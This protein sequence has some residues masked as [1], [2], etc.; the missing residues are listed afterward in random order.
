MMLTAADHRIV[1]L[2]DVWNTLPERVRAAD[3]AMFEAQGRDEDEYEAEAERA[4]E[5]RC[6][7]FAGDA[8]LTG[9]DWAG[10]RKAHGNEWLVL[11]VNGDLDFAG[12]SLPACYVAGDV[13]CDSLHASPDDAPVVGGRITARHYAAFIGG[14]DETLHCAFNGR[15][16]TPHAFFW[17]HDWRGVELNGDAVVHILCDHGDFEEPDAPRWFYWHDGLLALRPELTYA[18]ATWGSDELLWR[19]DDLGRRVGAGEPVFIDGFDPACLPLVNQAR[20]HLRHQQYPQALAHYK[21]AIA[22]ASGYRIAWAGAARTLYLADALEQALPYAERAMALMPDKLRHLKDEAADDRALCLLRLGRWDE[23]LAGASDIIERCKDESGRAVAHRVRGEAFLRRGA[24]EKARDD[25]LQAA[26]TSYSS[27]LYQWLAGLAHHKLGDH[28]AAE[29]LRAKAGRINEKYAMAFEGHEGSGFRYAPPTT[30]D[31]EQQTLADLP[32]EVRDADYWHRYLLS[33]AYDSAKSFRAIPAEFLTRDFCLEAIERCPHQTDI[34]VAQFFPEAVFDETL[35]ARL[36][37]RSAGN[38]G[39]IPQRLV[40]K[41]LLL[42]AGEGRCDPALVPPQLLDAE[43]CRRLVERQVPPDAL[44]PQ[45]VDHALCLHAVR[46]WSNAIEHVPGAFKDE[47]FY[48][49]ALAWADSLWFIENR[50]PARYHAPDMLCRAL[51]MNF[52]LIHHIPGRLVDEEVF[53]HARALCP[54]EA[55]W[56]QLTTAHGRGFRQASDRGEYLDCAEDCW[57][58]FWDEPLM[59]AEIANTGYHLFPFEIPAAKYTQTIADAAFARDPIHLR[60]IP[61]AFI[62]P[63]MAERFAREYA[64]MLHDVPLP[65][66]TARVCQIAAEHSWDD[67]KYFRHV[68]L[69]L[70]GVDACIAALGK[71]VDNADFI[72]LAARHAVYDRLVQGGGAK[73]FAIGWLLNER[74]LGALAL[75]RVDEAVA[76]FDTV[77]ARGRG[78]RKPGLLGA[79]FGGRPAWKADDFDEDDIADARLYKAWACRQQGRLDAMHEALA[80]LDEAQRAHLDIFAPAEAPEAVEFPLEA[81]EAHIGAAGQYVE[82]G[83]YRSALDSALQARTLLEEAQHPDPRLWAYALDHL[84]FIT[85]ELG[86]FDENERLCRQILERLQPV[87]DWPYLEEHN[88][89]RAARRG[90]HN[91]LAWKLADSQDAAD[92][93]QAVTHARAALRH[94][95]IED[96]SVVHPFLETAARAL[97]RA[98]EADPARQ[99]EARRMLERIAALGLAQ[100]GG[101]TDARVL[102]ALQALA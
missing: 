60:S 72:P 61:R 57:A 79:L 14:D 30:V 67:G 63:Q 15:V 54:D 92:I 80:P 23:A 77:I 29:A 102:A 39:Y 3:R 45:W 62:T 75:G 68:P 33:Q 8:R 55:L 56:A 41:A 98:A 25:L 84:R 66:R 6:V 100:K 76:D 59:L 51:D 10:L 46:H 88:I 2:G 40:T 11:V 31:W 21:A 17:F 78:T 13:V 85:W 90:A 93:A 22:L 9:D 52:G 7:F 53:A 37:E 43:L 101:I 49:T 94:A 24:L 83:D 19:L 89:L 87:A 16:T 18:P 69:A 82:G 42:R 86:R 97:L 4:R 96:E 91:T 27:A 47:A 74:G 38:L 44:P 99:D 20:T 28:G 50:L 65:L 48:L 73:D 95:P 12:R 58:V 71:S 32:A 26:K 70:R 35:A 36:I 34:W 1:L 81:Y 5:R 64:D